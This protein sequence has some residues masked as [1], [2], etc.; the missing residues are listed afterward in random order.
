M[1]MSDKCW[2]LLADI[3]TAKSF[4][5]MMHALEVLN[6]ER[7]RREGDEQKG[8]RRRY[9]GISQAD[10]RRVRDKMD[11]PGYLENIDSLLKQRG[12]IIFPLPETPKGEQMVVQEDG[13]S[14]S[15]SVHRV[16]SNFESNAED[17]IN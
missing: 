12:K 11:E 17:M 14:D 1:K 10:Y 3:A 13:E 7:D 6:F 16:S 5:D 2:R 9:K 15:E 4:R 8:R